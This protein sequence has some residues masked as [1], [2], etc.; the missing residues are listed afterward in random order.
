[1]FGALKVLVT[2]VA[3]DMIALPTPL[4]VFFFSLQERLQNDGVR[5]S[6]NCVALQVGRHWDSSTMYWISHLDNVCINQIWFWYNTH[7]P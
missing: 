1:M 6:H 5:S 4:K 7:V 2:C 3:E